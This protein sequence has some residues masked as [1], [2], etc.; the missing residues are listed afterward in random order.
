M[1]ILFSKEKDKKIEKRYIN[2]KVA[3]FIDGGNMFHA[4]NYINIKI[5][6]RKL[7][8]FLAKDRWLLR[9]YFYTGIP[10][11]DF[12]EEMKKQWKKQ[13]SFLNELKNIGIKVRT[14]PLKK[15]PEGF[16]EK[17][18][19]I[20]LATDMLSLAFRDAYDTAILVSGDSDYIPVVEEI[21]QLGKRVE[22]VSFKKTSSYE[23]RNVCDKYMILDKY[24]DLFTYVDKQIELKKQPKITFVDKIKEILKNII[25]GNKK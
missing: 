13:K 5:D 21:Q 14:M 2:E 4:S 15:T 22:N 1:S 18:V 19:D 9:A 12:P 8:N 10:Q 17:G 3:I 16:I 6:Y 23:L 24:I 20:L 7:V 25:K 11:G